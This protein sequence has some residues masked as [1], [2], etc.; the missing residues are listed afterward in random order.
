MELSGAAY[1]KDSIPRW[2]R[3]KELYSDRIRKHT[4]WLYL[5]LRREIDIAFR[6]EACPEGG[7]VLLGDWQ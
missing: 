2:F 3:L 7:F 5:A 1:R 4:V 6:S